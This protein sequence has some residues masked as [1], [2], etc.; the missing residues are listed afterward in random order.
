MNKFKTGEF[1]KVNNPKSSLNGYTYLIMNFSI[2]DN[3][4]RYHC[5]RVNDHT[6][7]FTN[8]DRIWIPETDL[9]ST[10]IYNGDV[11]TKNKKDKQFTISVRKHKRL[12]LNFKL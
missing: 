7:T 10:H 6:F 8:W 9:V 12:N 4:T 3:C 2:I 1:V 11:M 5:Q